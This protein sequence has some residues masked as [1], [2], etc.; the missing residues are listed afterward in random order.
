L[1]ARIPAGWLEQLAAAPVSSLELLE[2]RAIT[3]RW[4]DVAPH[5]RAAALRMVE[6]RRRFEKISPEAL[7]ALE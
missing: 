1:T 6:V 5:A 2:Y 3:S 4:R 7:R